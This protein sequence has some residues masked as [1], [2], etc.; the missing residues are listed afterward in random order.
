MQSQECYHNVVSL[1]LHALPMM[2]LAI[3]LYRVSSDTH[4]CIGAPFDDSSTCTGLS[5]ACMAAWRDSTMFDRAAAGS[6]KRASTSNLPASRR[7]ASKSQT[8][9]LVFE[10]RCEEI[11][12]HTELKLVEPHVNIPKSSTSLRIAVIKSVSFRMS[13]KY[14]RVSS[15]MPASSP[16]VRSRST[17]PQTPAHG[18]RYEWYLKITLTLPLIKKIPTWHSTT[19]TC[20]RI[21]D[22]VADKGCT[23]RNQS[24]M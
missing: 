14:R 9:A 4:P 23:K 24:R 11:I 7:P 16:D 13:Y 18:K 12:S 1:T 19:R 15:S 22:L 6:K 5:C 21:A 20:K 2:L 3:C 17:N 10:K 8:Y